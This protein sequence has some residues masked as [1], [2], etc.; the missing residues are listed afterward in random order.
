[1]GEQLN[2]HTREGWKVFKVISLQIAMGTMGA[3]VENSIEISH[4]AKAFGATQAV[5][6]VSFEVTPGEIFGLLGLNGAGETT[7]IR[8]MLDIFKPD[9]GTV[10]ILGG[11][12]TEEK[13]DRIGYM[14]EKRGCIKMCPWSAVWST[15]ESL[16]GCPML[17]HIHAS[18]PCS[19]ASNW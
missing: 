12:M 19:S 17:M 8:L 9:R 7:T 1:M 10:S 3:M 11:P 6:D 16:K 18:S 4:V 13:K 5:V 15:W 14:P 2:Q